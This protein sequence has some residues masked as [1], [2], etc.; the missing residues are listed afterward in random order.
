MSEI[1]TA[2]WSEW[3]HFLRRMGLDGLAAALLEGAGPLTML[4]AQCIYAGQPLVNAEQANRWQALA[5]ML[6]NPQ[7]GQAFATFLRQEIVH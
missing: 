4:L 6:E 3:A 7:A 1:P 5:Q 2:L